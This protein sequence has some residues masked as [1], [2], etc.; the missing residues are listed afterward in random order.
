[1]Q[2]P[3]GLLSKLTEA[4]TALT[5]WRTKHELA[6]HAGKAP[7]V[8]QTLVRHA[9]DL[10]SK[11]EPFIP[12]VVSQGIAAAEKAVPGIITGSANVLITEAN[13][14]ADEA[15]KKLGEL[16]GSV[17]AIPEPLKKDLPV[18][19]ELVTEAT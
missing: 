1:M 5:A 17:D 13:A 2:S 15:L 12:P 11:A 16:F 9:T 19:L 14:A 18:K 6:L 3:N 7:G 8:A 10:R 4:T